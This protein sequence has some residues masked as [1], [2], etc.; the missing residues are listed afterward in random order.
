MGGVVEK[1]RRHTKLRGIEMPKMNLD[2]IAKELFENISVTIEGVEYTVAKVTAETLKVDEVTDDADLLAGCRQLARLLGAKPTT[3]D[4][5]DLRV[6]GRAVKFITDE[7]VAQMGMQVKNSP[8]AE[9][10]PSG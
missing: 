7:I 5:T 3:F 1:G 9:G 8:V 4:K 6:V 10:T 2:E